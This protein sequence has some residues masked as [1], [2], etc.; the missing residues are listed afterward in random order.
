M[1][2]TKYYLC[3]KHLSEKYKFSFIV[4]GKNE[5]WKLSLCFQSI[6]N[7]IEKNRIDNYEI[8]YVDSRSTDDSIERAKKIPNIKIF[9]IIGKCNAAIARNIGCKEAQVDILFFFDGDM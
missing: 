9:S 5:G 1:K 8:I 4:I 7:C 2:T 6:L 3:M